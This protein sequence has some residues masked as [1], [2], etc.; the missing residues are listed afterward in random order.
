MASEILRPSAAGDLT[1]ID[2]QY[3]AT[4][5]HWDKVDDV[6]PD[7]DDTKVYNSTFPSNT[8]RTDLYTIQNSS[9]GAGTITKI[10]I[11]ARWKR[12]G[13]YAY[14]I[15]F[16]HKL[17]THD[18]VYTGPRFDYLGDYVYDYWEI[19]TNPFTGGAWTWGEI[20]A[21]QAG[22]TLQY[23]KGIGVS[24][25][26]HCTQVYVQVFFPPGLATT[27][28]DYAT[29]V[30]AAAASLNGT[31]DGDGGDPCDCGFEWGLTTDYGETTSTESKETGETFSQAISGLVGGTAYH[32]R[33][34]ATNATGTGYGAD[35]VLVAGESTF[36]TDTVA[37]VSSIR[38][39]FRP[40]LFRMQAGLGD[41]GFDVDVAETTVR[42]EL[43]TAKD[44][45]AGVGY[46][47][48]LEVLGITAEE[49]VE[50][51]RKRTRKPLE[52]PAYEEQIAYEEWFQKQME[53]LRE[54][55]WKG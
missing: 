8:T 2:D 31:L 22:I 24:S 13:G 36:P 5:E 49:F 26:G 6:T 39:I 21:L 29:S 48:I 38:H 55:G 11:Y 25:T 53:E 46:P 19:T 54:M 18:T 15:D 3:P 41:L 1:Q 27:T 40:G 47:E 37:R 43:D 34:F 30:E 20:N 44:V 35:K 9:I 32:F 28:T 17:K 14:A 33:A 16:W 45:T 52:F 42:R 23:W 51:G 10:R 50:R 12:S 4:G 7:D